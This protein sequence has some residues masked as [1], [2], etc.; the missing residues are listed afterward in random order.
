[1]KPVVHDQTSMKTAAQI[2]SLL[3]GK[4]FTYLRTNSVGSQFREDSEIFPEQF[5]LP[6]SDGNLVTCT[7]LKELCFETNGL[8]IHFPAWA[9]Y[10]IL[11]NRGV[12]VTQSDA[13][14]NNYSGVSVH[15]FTITGPLRP[16]LSKLHNKEYRKL[17]RL[18]NVIQ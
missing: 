11:P 17:L 2:A 5:L 14:V 6:G 7:M 12:A 16:D 10:T 8:S 18:H 15:Y 9:R 13:H 1:M 3:Q 4:V